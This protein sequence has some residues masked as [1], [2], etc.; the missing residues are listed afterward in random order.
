MLPASGEDPRAPI[1]STETSF[2]G[3]ACVRRLVVVIAQCCA[4]PAAPQFVAI[5]L[6]L[7]LASGGAA[8]WSVRELRLSIRSY[9]SACEAN[10]KEWRR[11]NLRSPTTPIRML[12][13]SVVAIRCSGGTILLASCCNQGADLAGG[14]GDRAVMGVGLAPRHFGDQKFEVVGRTLLR[15]L[16]GL[17]R[18]NECSS[19]PFAQSGLGGRQRGRHNEWRLFED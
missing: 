5:L 16:P 12:P 14:Y 8:V 3:H 11:G 7:A 9:G 18:R 15:M 4:P 1:F 10:I 6:R 2:S 17:R 13:V 19:V